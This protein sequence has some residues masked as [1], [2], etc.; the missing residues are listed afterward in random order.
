MTLTTLP[1][2]DIEA[3][4][5]DWTAQFLLEYGKNTREAY[6]S[7]LRIFFQ[8]CGSVGVRA[9]DAVR[10]TCS[11]FCRAQVEIEQ[12]SPST[13]SRRLAAISAWFR[14]AEAEGFIEA[15]PM[16]SVRRPRVSRESVST[17][18]D[19]TELSSLVGAAKTDSIQSYALILL[20]SMNG[21]RISEALGINLDD[22]GTERGHVTIKIRRKGGK[23]GV[24]PLN[25]ITAGAIAHLAAVRDDGPLFR[26]GEGRMT[27]Q[28]SW[29]LVRKLAKRAMPEKAEEVHP[30]SFRHAFATLSLDAGAPLH[31]VQDAMGHSDP[32]TTQL[33]NRSRNNLDSHPCFL[34]GSD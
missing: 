33:Y 11:A 4:R 27:R 10:S 19:K 9:Q 13:V 5:P 8:W 24:C 22:L 1:F 21:L 26:T 32:R 12:Y 31:V 29:R 14:Y 34:L 23:V 16:A 18:L 28:G 6:A 25:S 20:L 17:G 2:T 7:D 15:N 30:H 3:F